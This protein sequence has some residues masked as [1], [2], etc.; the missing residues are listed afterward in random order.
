MEGVYNGGLFRSSKAYSLAS[1]KEG[2]EVESLR[3]MR[4]VSRRQQKSL[5]DEHFGQ[6]PKKN[7]GVVRG[8]QM[9]PTLGLDIIM[10]K[11]SRSLSHAFNLK[12][13]MTVLI[14][15]YVCFQL[16][17]LKVFFFF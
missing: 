9:R 16:L 14:E 13:A 3:R 6:D 1:R 15:K 2:Q 11:Q 5:R 12:R 7:S 17:L 8:I 10:V 4:S